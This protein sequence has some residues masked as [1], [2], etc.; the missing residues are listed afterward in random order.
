MNKFNDQILCLV[1]EKKLNLNAVREYARRGCPT[2]LRGRLWSTM[3]DIEL[4]NWVN[5][6]FHLLSLLIFV[7]LAFSVFQLSQTEYHRFRSSSR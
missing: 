4:S 1:L 6:I 7:C 3:L 5:P 2:S